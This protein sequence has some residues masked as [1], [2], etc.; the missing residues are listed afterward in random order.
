MNLPVNRRAV[1][2]KLPAALLVAGGLLVACAVAVA[3]VQLNGN[4]E[5]E[6]ASTNT[7]TMGAMTHSSGTSTLP[8]HPIAGNFK[9][10]ETQLADCQGD[11]RC[12]EQAFG[13]I[14]YYDGPEAAFRAFEQRMASDPAFASDCHRTAH[15]IGSAALA[16][17]EGN[18]AEAF[19]RGSSTCA[20]GYYHGILEHSFAKAD[21][22]S[23]E[24]FGAVARELCS[25]ADVRRRP[26]LLFQCIHGIGHGLMI[27]SGYDLPF[28]LNVCDRLETG[29]DQRS[30][31]GGAFM[32]NIS[33]SYGIRS[34][35][36]RDDDLIYPCNDVPEHQ[37]EGC[38]LI[39][40]GRILQAN[41]FDWQEAART[42]WESDRRW[43]DTCVQSYGRDAAGFSVFNRD[44]IIELCAL[45]G[46]G[47]AACF[48][49]AVRAIANNFM[50]VRP[51][52]ALCDE[53]P[54]RSKP[55]CFYGVGTYVYMLHSTVEEQRRVCDELSGT[56]ADVCMDGARDTAALRP[57]SA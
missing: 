13:N 15:T 21:A 22:D 20:S 43:I 37:K 33:S 24:E 17:Y 23:E 41:G 27:R 6:A 19:V 34:T 49:G 26:Y 55:R 56:Y 11:Q 14:T 53:A 9:P 8:A 36:L 42:C 12:Y 25:D 10:D 3:L 48:Y 50:T 35:W 44:R 39:V 2:A 5:P 47:D 1:R 7:T 31:H 52:A 46:S 57:Q 38:Y 28:S 4:D 16:R 18:V 54:S 45:A 29:W 40:T 51:A 30:C 32:E